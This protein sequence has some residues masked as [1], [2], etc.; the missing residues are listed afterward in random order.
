MKMKHGLSRICTNVLTSS[1]KNSMRQQPLCATQILCITRSASSSCNDDKLLNAFRTCLFKRLKQQEV[2]PG[3][4]VSIIGSGAVGMACAVALLSKG[5][6]NDIALYDINKDLCTAESADLVHG[7]LFL[8]NC[9][10]AK[11]CDI[12]STRD[13]RVVVV[14]SGV[15]PK[16]N[17]KPSEVA[18]KTADIIKC[19]MPSLVK[20][21]PKAVFIIV[22]NPSDVM[23]WVA[24][25]ISKLPYERCISTGCHLDTARFR[26][27]IA[28]LLGVAT[29]S[30]NAFVLGENGERSVPMW[31]SVTVGGVRLEQLVPKIGTSEDPMQWCKVH[32]DVV[33]AAAKVIALKGYTNWAIGHAVADVVSAIFENSNRILSLSTNAKGMCGIKDD[34]FLSLP[35]IVNKWGLFGIIRPHLS[36][37]ESNAM[38]K[39]A[40]Q[41]L[42]AQCDIK[43]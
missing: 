10:V 1:I 31:S 4:K 34:I 11:C 6:T 28:Q 20:E 14:T 37:W 16:A 42:K 39:S 22:S 36:K 2:Q 27:F 38:K 23:A 40:E 21:S 29:S 41:V 32:K 33:E 19:V 26:L 12:G 5:I 35:C 9:N 8:N 25:K 17:E 30:V 7:S 18:Q 43:L 15:R 13:S 3:N 24:H